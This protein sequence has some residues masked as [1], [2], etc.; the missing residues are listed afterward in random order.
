MREGQKILG[1]LPKEHVNPRTIP[2]WMLL[3]IS[4]STVLLI[5]LGTLAAMVPGEYILPL[6]HSKGQRELRICSRDFRVRS[7]ISRQLYLDNAAIRYQ[8]AHSYMLCAAARI[9][10]FRS[11]ELEKFAKFKTTVSASRL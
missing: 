2:T 6:L 9:G 8:R 10:S 7:D 11:P 4:S 5:V 1:L 3:T